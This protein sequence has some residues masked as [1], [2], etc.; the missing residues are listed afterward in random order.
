[1]GGEKHFQDGE[2][3]QARNGHG[4]SQNGIT[5]PTAEKSRACPY[6]LERGMLLS[7]GTG[8]AIDPGD[9]SGKRVMPTTTLTLPVAEPATPYRMNSPGVEECLGLPPVDVKSYCDWVSS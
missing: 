9:G 7:T 2:A 8:T 4:I 3:S 5:F 6:L 1:M